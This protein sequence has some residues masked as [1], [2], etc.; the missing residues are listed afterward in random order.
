MLNNSSSRTYCLNISYID[1]FNKKTWRSND[2]FRKISILNNDGHI[3]WKAGQ[4]D[5]GPFQPS[6]VTIV[7]RFPTRVSKEDILFL[8]TAA[9]FEGSWI[10][11]G[12]YQPSMIK[13]GQLVSG[14]VKSKYFYLYQQWSYF[15]LAG[16]SDKIIK[17]INQG[18]SQ[19]SLVNIGKMV[20]YEMSKV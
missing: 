11:Q 7:Q 14:D 20:L 17:G 6:L 2:S 13:S 12:P 4:S 5:K 16:M 18:P 19:S 15:R 1:N 10:N 9:I 3:C 8:V